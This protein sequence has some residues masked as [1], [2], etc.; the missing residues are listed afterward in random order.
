[1]IKQR[2]R[3]D[4]QA[5]AAVRAAGGYTTTNGTTSPMHAGG[6]NGNVSGRDT[7]ENIDRV[8]HD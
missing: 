2:E 3:A 8:E 5:A 6:R 7:V 4:A 1:M